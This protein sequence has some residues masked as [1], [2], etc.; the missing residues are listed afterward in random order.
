MFGLVV[1]PRT[2]NQIVF[3]STP[4]ARA[5]SSTLR[6]SFPIAAQKLDKGADRLLGR[7]AQGSTSASLRMTWL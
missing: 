4:E 1:W 2:E 7:L 5:M 3:L 6:G